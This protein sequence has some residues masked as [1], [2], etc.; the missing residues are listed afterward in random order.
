MCTMYTHDLPINTSIY[1]GVPV[2]TFDYQR[3]MGMCQLTHMRTTATTETLRTA[4]NFLALFTHLANPID[5]DAGVK[6]GHCFN[7]VTTR[8]GVIT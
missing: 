7:C 1:G 6:T 8:T 5:V 2:A 4:H 3:I